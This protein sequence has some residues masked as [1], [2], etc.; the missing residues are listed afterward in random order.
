MN[1]SI[2]CG[3]ICTFPKIQILGA[4]PDAITLC[5]FVIAVPEDTNRKEANSYDFFEC[6]C[7]GDAAKKIANTFTKHSK[8]VVS[9][10]FKNF[11]FDDNM[12]TKHFTNIF[13]VEKIEF[14]DTESYMSRISKKKTVAEKMISAEHVN[15]D[16]LFAHICECGFMVI[17]ESDYYRLAMNLID[18]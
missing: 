13:V 16:E 12:N 15:T 4:A 6:V 3:S 18:V 10:R 1:Q 2:I 7:V 8:V 17:D 5:T 9:G 14:G 11:R